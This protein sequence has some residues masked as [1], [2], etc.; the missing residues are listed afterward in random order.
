MSKTV[1][2]Y[3]THLHTAPVS[4]CARALPDEQVRAYAA[5]GYAGVIVTDHFINGNCS[6]PRDIPWEEKMRY[7]HSG[8]QRA[9]A[10]GERLGVDV[11]FGWEYAVEGTEFL[12]YGL[13][14]DFLLA[15]P[16]MD[17]LTP[18]A[19]SAL[20]RKR[21]GYMAQAHPYRVDSWI[22]RPGPVCPLLLDGVEVCNA[23]MPAHVNGQAADFA[24]THGLPPQS[25]SDSHTADIAFAA[26]IALPRKA[27][28][29][30]DIIA[31]I[32]Q[33][34]ARLITPD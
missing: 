4:A 9:R 7:F 3:E 24:E 12:T 16:G 33:R 15:H 17:R 2:L 31:A 18:E 1:Y 34:K 19:Y 10:E 21:G 30:F 13:D 29:I 26:G 6:C 11:F 20:I 14:L 32:R 25:G 23:S 22:R 5:R 27:K 8:F 28:D